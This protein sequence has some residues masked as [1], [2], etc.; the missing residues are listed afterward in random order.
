MTVLVAEQV[1]FA[2]G[3]QP[4]L[5][6]IDL[7][8][9][10]GCCYGILGPNGSGKTT[11]LDLFC[12]LLHPREGRLTFMDRE[13]PKWPVRA[14]ARH[15][16]LVPQEFVIRFGFTV[17]E[18]VAMGRHPHLHRFASLD[19]GD[20][21]LVER[22]MEEF[23]IDHLADRPVTRLS[24]GEKQRVAVARALVQEP[25]VLL[26]DE[27]TSNLDIYH[28]LAILDVIRGRIRDQGLTVVAAL[29]DLNL[30]AWFCDELV[31]LKE[32][33][34]TSRGRVDQV[35]VPEIIDEVYGVCSRVRQDRFTGGLQ[36]SFKRRSEDMV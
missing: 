14:L 36:V 19:P 8:C 12:G 4:V 10:G 15:L 35:L 29:H 25:R 5:A 2:Y 13:L 1:S 17:R 16:A 7:A 30:A 33:R 9:E 3:N 21:R 18:V 27:A 32:G 6:G 31:F 34:M 22:T 24:G 26:L 23:G 28:T 11:L 20:H